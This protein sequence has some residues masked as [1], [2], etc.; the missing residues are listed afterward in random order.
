MHKEEPIQK[1]SAADAPDGN[2]KI[3]MNRKGSWALVASLTLTA[4]Q[5]KDA[6]NHP[7]LSPSTETNSTPVHRWLTPSS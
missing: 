1:P 3:F 2:V 7:E 4:A 6:T 5:T